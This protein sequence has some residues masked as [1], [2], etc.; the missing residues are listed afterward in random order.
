[1][2][3]APSLKR[4]FVRD[5]TIWGVGGSVVSAVVALMF[6]V[7][8]GVRSSE[9]SI[10]IAARSAASGFRT[11]ILAQDID[12]AE[13]AIRKDFKLSPSENVTIRDPEFKRICE[14]G[15]LSS[16]NQNPLCSKVDRVCWD[17]KKFQV[18][19]LVP[20]YF[21]SS[22]PDSI[23]SYL[24]LNLTPRFDFTLLALLFVA[25]LG[26]T[27]AQMIGLTSRS[28]RLVDSVLSQ[29]DKWADHI[30]SNPKETL[31][32][33]STPYKEL[34]SLQVA[35][36]GL[37]A[38]I[39]RL[40]TEARDSGKLSVIRGISHDLLSPISQLQKMVGILE[41]DVLSQAPSSSELVER[42]KRSLGRLTA[43]AEKTRHLQSAMLP[44]QKKEESSVIDISKET[45]ILISD[46]QKDSE[47]ESKK[48]DLIRRGEDDSVLATIPSDDYARIVSNLLRNAAQA[49]MPSA[50]IEIETRLEFSSP[51]LIVR[52][53]GQGIPPAI[54]K[55]IFD[56]DF[57][58]KPSSGTGLGLSI[59]RE[60]CH[61]NGA[62]ISFASK[63][64]QGTEF[65]IR[66]RSE[67]KSLEVAL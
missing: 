67:S 50:K 58:T 26:V 16:T 55:K 54:R 60:L 42:M 47:I 11:Q 40:E 13:L 35:L 63:E 51:T 38:E 4:T 36:E 9:R 5:L 29:L 25:I 57:T 8:L 20:V 39:E 10:E 44:S 53:E 12:D 45:G 17:L 64:G 15:N 37:N 6:V 32:S 7:F 59:V 28:V 22:R 43:M 48:I 56:L 46:L 19:M 31:K 24:E 21:D 61:K 33:D 18:G 3:L 49:S 65:R 27:V 1:M 14:H 62:E 52:D 66:F 41:D 30:R 34:G 2:K 23:Q